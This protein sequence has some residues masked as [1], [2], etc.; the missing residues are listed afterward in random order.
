M[1]FCPFNVMVLSGGVVRVEQDYWNEDILNKYEYSK[2]ILL[3]FCPLS[4][5]SKSPGYPNDSTE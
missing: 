4:R 2:N 1:V 5:G 3:Y